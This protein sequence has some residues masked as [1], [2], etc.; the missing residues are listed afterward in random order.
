MDRAATFTELTKRNALRREA[1][2]PLLDLHSEM[3][4]AVE[5]DAHRA[6]TEQCQTYD[7]ER[8][9]IMSD[10]LKELRQVRGGNFPSSMGGRMLIRLMSDQRFRAFLE[11]DHGIRKP[12]MTGRHPISYGE[13]RRS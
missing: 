8:R 2:L 13:L 1:K 9:R 11:I 5:L 3:T 12:T 7:D 6:Y 4:L 10:V